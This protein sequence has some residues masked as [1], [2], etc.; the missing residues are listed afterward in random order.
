MADFDEED[1]EQISL[2]V[3]KITDLID[4]C[5]RSKLAA[6]KWNP[7]KV[8]GWTKDIVDTVL[9]QL[10]EMKKPFKFVVTCIIMQKVGAGLQSA[11]CTKGEKLRDGVFSA[12]FDND[13]LYCV[14]TVF[15]LKTD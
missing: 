1:Q 4:G 7:K 10:A 11:F 8:D 13:H 5:M 3:E 12:P 2:N 15:G 14:T 9:K 6:E